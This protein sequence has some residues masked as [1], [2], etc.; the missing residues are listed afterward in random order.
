MTRGI[1][2]G[3]LPVLIGCSIWACPAGDPPAFEVASVKA[4]APPPAGGR[5][6]YPGPR[7][8]GGPGS[9]DPTR[10]DYTNVSMSYLVSVA[11]GVE[12][13]QVSGPDWMP[14]NSYDITARV[15]PAT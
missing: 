7:M 1:L 8:N 5:G 3:L 14:V 10:I 4:S 13:W 6:F 9:G 2:I 11:Y 12:Y 15:P